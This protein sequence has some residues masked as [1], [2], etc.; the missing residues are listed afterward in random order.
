VEAILE[1]AKASDHVLTDHEI[2]SVIRAM[3]PR[4]DASAAEAA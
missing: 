4:E 2:G 3:Q 1:R